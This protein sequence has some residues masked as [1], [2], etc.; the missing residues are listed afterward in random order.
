MRCH[1]KPVTSK[2]ARSTAFIRSSSSL[3]KAGLNLDRGSVESL[4][5]ITC[6]N[7]RSPLPVV[8]STVTRK[9]A[10]RKSLVTGHSTTLSR[11]SSKSLWLRD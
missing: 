11:A 6:D 4:S 8:G 9:A 10:V 2:S 7:T 1:T 5:T 3:P